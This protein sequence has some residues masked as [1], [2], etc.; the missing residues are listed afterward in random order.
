MGPAELAASMPP[1]VARE[2]PRR[3]YVRDLRV[4]RRLLLTVMRRPYGG[5][6][7]EGAG[8][9]LSARTVRL[10]RC[11]RVFAGGWRSIRRHD[12]RHPW[13]FSRYRWGFR[14]VSSPLSEVRQGLPE[15]D[16]GDPGGSPPRRGVH[17]GA[18]VA[19]ATAAERL[20]ERLGDGGGGDPE[21]GWSAATGTAGSCGAGL[22]SGGRTGPGDTG[23]ACAGR[24]GAAAASTEGDEAGPAG[25]RVARAR[26]SP[27]GSRGESRR[28]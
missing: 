5:L 1:A 11:G 24:G 12:G 2:V 3:P 21:G 25:A 14:H 26:S 18:V 10:G 27:L 23:E 6:P 15:V 28:G 19:A 8:C 7:A 20:G 17:G 4:A 22:R 16:T 9:R 13:G